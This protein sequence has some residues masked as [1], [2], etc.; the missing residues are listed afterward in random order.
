MKKHFF[1]FLLLTGISIKTFT[2]II[3]E[4]GYF[5]DDA[6]QKT[7][8][9]IKNLDWRDNPTTFEYKLTQNTTVQQAHIQ[10][11]QEFGINGSA[12]YIR[13]VV[14]I[15]RSSDQIDLMSNK[16]NPIYEKEQL[17]LEVI[18]EGDASLYKYQEGDL[19][20][21]FFQKKDAEITQLVYKRYMK[22][23]GIAT[24]N[25][26]IQQLLN[27]FKDQGISMAD[28]RGLDY[29]QKQLKRF[30]IDLNEMMYSDYTNYYPKKE[31]DL[32]NLSLRPGLN[33]HSLTVN[34]PP[35]GDINFDNKYVVSL[36]IEAE[37]ILP[38]KKNKWAIAVEPTYAYYNAEKEQ[39]TSYA[40]G[41]ILITKVNYHLIQLP[42]N[43]RHYFFL[44]DDSK[45]FANFSHTFN[46]DKNSTIDFR[47]KDNS[48]I[49]T[50]EI[51]S[52]YSFGIGVG[53]KYDNKYSIEIRYQTKRDILAQ[54]LQ[55]HADFQSISVML[56][57][58]IF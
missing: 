14:N 41:G 55:F 18:I 19:T 43:V 9:L 24:N 36:G 44:N 33:I 49:R 51:K 26:Y 21:F 45:L 32:F 34:A 30:F 6:S 56:G 7:E 47:R 22:D 5:I 10:S 35:F 8:C 40:S 1:L 52:N 29:N 42:V 57:Y 39:E 12:K 20:R 54:Y 25:Y 38:Y 11:V 27:A 23:G 2:Q 17:F 50:Y 3:F 37:F 4:P 31:Q 48:L 16:R 28:V 53:Y 58:T 13:A 46:F 15:D